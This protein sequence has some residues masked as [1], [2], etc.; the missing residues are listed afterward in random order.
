MTA[1]V[2]HIGA[3]KTGTSVVQRFLRDHGRA[4]KRRRVT[5]IGRSEIGD[6]VGWGRTLVD[7]PDRMA[8]RLAR[9][10][11]NPYYRTLLATTE[12][13]LGRPIRPGGEHL[14]PDAVPVIHALEKVLDRYD[15]RVIWYV[16]P[17]DEFVESYYLQLIH[18]GEHISFD[19]W[20]DTIDPATLSW[21]PVATELRQ[22]FGPRAV[23]VGFEEVRLGQTEFLRR[24]FERVDPRLRLPFA[25]ERRHNR[26]ISAK[27]LDLALAANPL[28][29]AKR[30]QHALRV[31]LQSHFSNVDYERPT[32]LSPA[33]R[34]DLADRYGAEYAGITGASSVALEA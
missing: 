6:Y 8:R 10:V 33:Q 14:Y 23:I 20:F 30:E 25:Y 12:N 29:T 4:L 16:R 19:E 24:F 1:V 26:S 28:L 34:A 31:F 9:G 18:Q 13:A 27:G 15:G 21:E 7:E 5:Y 3:H 32:L 11:A 2:F 22:V 17:V